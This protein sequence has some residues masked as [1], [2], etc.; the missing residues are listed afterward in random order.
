MNHHD[1]LE[2]QRLDVKADQLSH[3]RAMLPQRDLLVAA[4]VEGRRL[5]DEI[6]RLALTQIKVATRQKRYEDE[7]QIVAA[8]IETDEVRLYSGEVTA[9]RD[10]QALQAE[11]ASLQNRQSGLEDEALAAMEEAES[12]ASQV[13]GLNSEA[14]LSD[15]R[16]GA[17]SV[18][19]EA[20]ESEIDAQLETIRSKRE[21]LEA[22][23]DSSLLDDYRRLRPMFGSA[24]V[25]RFEGN[26]CV[27]CPSMM[28]AMEVDRMKH[29]TDADVL[30]CDECGRI[31]LL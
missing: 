31:V 2:V 5:T 27:G 15:Q 4:Q 16:I 8:R 26:K 14:E 17:L 20:A 29:A 3:K 10:L 1:L 30:S 9:L 13:V 21:D 11:I 12:L 23:L 19:I 28:P 7:A 25:V 24:T 18:E 6:D 22:A